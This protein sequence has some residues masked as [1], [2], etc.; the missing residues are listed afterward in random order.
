MPPAM[1]S[2]VP[3]GGENCRRRV[4]REAAVE[5]HRAVEA[6]LGVRGRHRQ[7][8]WRRGAGVEEDAARPVITFVLPTLIAPVVFTK[9]T[10]PRSPL[11]R[12]VRPN[13][14]PPSACV[15]V[16][17]PRAWRWPRL[18]LKE[19]LPAAAV[20][21]RLSLPPAMLSIVPAVV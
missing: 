4:D 6:D 3:R 13:N 5:R 18:A 2:I 12:A 10:G 7:E 14:T 19:T 20:R 8:C 17:W 16:T 11:N 21:V 15:T 9:A 1:L